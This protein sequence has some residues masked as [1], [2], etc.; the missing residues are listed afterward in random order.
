MQ[1]AGR[2]AEETLS[3]PQRTWLA[4]MKLSA[5]AGAFFESSGNFNLAAA[6]RVLTKD[7]SSAHR[8]FGELQSHFGQELEKLR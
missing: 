3:R 5:N 2:R 1:L 6:S 7:R 8:A 4:A